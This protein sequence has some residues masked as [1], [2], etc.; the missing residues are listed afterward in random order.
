LEKEANGKETK[1]ARREFDVW[2]GRKAGHLVIYIYT[3]AS[4]YLERLFVVKGCLI[5]HSSLT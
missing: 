5:S 3:T 4:I 2:N 1:K